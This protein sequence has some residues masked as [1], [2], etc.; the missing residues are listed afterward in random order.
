MRQL[1]ASRRHAQAVSGG[2]ERKIDV[3]VVSDN[4]LHTSRFRMTSGMPPTRIELVH[5]V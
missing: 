3:G 4:C 2:L 5:T 1:C